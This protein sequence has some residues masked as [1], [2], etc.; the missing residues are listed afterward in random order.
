M[1]KVM[2]LSLLAEVQELMVTIIGTHMP[3]DM[4]G[5]SICMLLKA[6][7]LTLEYALLLLPQRVVKIC[8]YGGANTSN[9]S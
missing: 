6:S 8:K 2:N 1:R 4:F 3:I 7:P 9:Q 5:N